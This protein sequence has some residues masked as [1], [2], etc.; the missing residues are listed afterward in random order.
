MTKASKR[1]IERLHKASNAMLEIVEGVGCV[2]WEHEGRRLKD[3]K[4]WVEFYL[5][6]HEANSAKSLL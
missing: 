3:T 1:K 2:R 5:A 4:Q 6:L